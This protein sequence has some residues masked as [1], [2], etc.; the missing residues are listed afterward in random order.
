MT[1][2][3]W[4][5]FREDNEIII[6][7]G[8]V[9]HPIRSW[10]E[11]NILPDYILK[12][13]SEAGF[14]RPSPIQMQGIPIGLEKRDMIGLAPTGSGKSLAFIIP[15]II[16]LNPLERITSVN[17]EHGPYAI[18]LAPSR[19]LA[20]QIHETFKTFAKSSNI[21]AALVIGGRSHDEQIIHLELGAEVIIATP[22]RLQDA[23]Q[24]GFTSLENCNY[25]VLDEADK[26]IKENFEES[27][28]Y[29]LDCIPSTNLKS[30]DEKL[31][32]IEE[33]ECKEG[34]KNY[35]ITMMFSATMNPTLESLARKYLRCPSYISIG[36]PG[37][38][39]KNIKQTVLFLSEEQKRSKLRHIL[40]DYDSYRLPMIIFVNKKRDADL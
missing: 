32:E 37:L 11:G 28:N 25:V 33:K 6:K 2:R 26:M 5:I 12:S 36:E 40:N 21:K 24:Q 23:L 16:Y 14:K 38:G 15:L 30:I 22:G 7:G 1:E 18:I 8:R 27:L 29:I 9:P 13:I 34:N 19:E 17:S 4:R 31:A 35:R 10:T 3:D 20:I 39:K